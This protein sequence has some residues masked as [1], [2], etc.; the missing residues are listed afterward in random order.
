M[1]LVK[2]AWFLQNWRE[3]LKVAW[4][5]QRYSR[6]FLRSLCDFYKDCVILAKVAYF[7]QKWRE[8][9][10]GC[11]ILVTFEPFLQK[12]FILKIFINTTVPKHKIIFVWKWFG[13][14][15]YFLRFQ[16]LQYCLKTC[17]IVLFMN[18]FK[19]KNWFELLY[20]YFQWI[21]IKYHHK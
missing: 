20:N 2:V 13:V 18:Y 12:Y 5:L 10:K 15:P 6:P 1:Y 3:S 7:L 9:C 8:S 4:F 11:V 14:A 16:R 17:I 19:E 21:L